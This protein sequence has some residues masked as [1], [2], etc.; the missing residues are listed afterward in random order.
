MTAP[1]LLVESIG[2]SFGGLKQIVNREGVFE[3]IQAGVIKVLRFGRY[4]LLFKVIYFLGQGELV[5]AVKK[6]NHRK[7]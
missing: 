6:I 3:S 2:I 4:I 1:L 5:F 7:F